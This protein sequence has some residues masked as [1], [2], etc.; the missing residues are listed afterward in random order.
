MR[1]PVGLLLLDL[2]GTVLAA[3]LTI[4]PR[5]R[6]AVADAMAAGVVVTIASGRMYRSLVPYARLLGLEAPLIA[7]QGALIRELPGLDGRPGRI[8]DHRPLDRDVARQALAWCLAQ[9][10][11]PHLNIHDRLI[12]AR[13]DEDTADY[14]RATGVNAEL[15]PDLAAALELL[16]DPP[17]KILAVG[18][19]GRPEA[20]L[21][22]ARSTFGQR[23]EVTV[24]HPQYLELTAPGVTKGR[25]M[26]WLADHLGIP[27]TATM[28]VGDHYNDLEMIAEAAWGVAMADAPEPVRAR[29]RYVTDSLERD[30]AALAIEAP[31][32]GRGGLD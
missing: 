12:I 6:A 2:D 1:S 31:V 11:D 4:R 15:V 9:G 3:D 5:V 21:E 29:A 32:L 18:P 22:A 13:S 24:S 16:P 28:A 30:G 26:R 8:L 20:L 25:A 19:A 14:E 10:L 23:V 7:Y 17:T 27:P